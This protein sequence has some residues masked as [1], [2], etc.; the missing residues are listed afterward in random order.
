[1]IEIRPVYYNRKTSKTGVK[2]TE[3]LLQINIVDHVPG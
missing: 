2:V 1:M 3:P